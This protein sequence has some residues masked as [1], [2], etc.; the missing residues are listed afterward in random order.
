ML[1]IGG[2]VV[3]GCLGKLGTHD[4]TRLNSLKDLFR[5]PSS[6][7]IQPFLSLSK[8]GGFFPFQK[9]LALTRDFIFSTGT[10]SFYAF[11]PFTFYAGGKDY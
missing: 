1:S 2:G 4:V 3:D 7:H 5:S 8:E 6:A 11:L 9:T 10:S